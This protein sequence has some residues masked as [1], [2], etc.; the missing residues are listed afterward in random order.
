MR[1]VLA[2][3]ALSVATCVKLSNALLAAAALVDRLPA[4]AGRA[5]RC[6]ISQALSRSR[7]SCRL[8]ADLLP[9][10]V[11]Q[12]PV[13][14]ARPVRPAHIVSS[15]THS[16]IFDAAHARDRRCRSRSSARSACA[17]RGRSRS[18]SRSC[19]STRSS[20][21]STRT[22][23]CIRA[24]S[25]RACPSSSCSG[26]RGRGDRRAGRAASGPLDAR[27]A[28]CA[29]A[30]LR[31]G[32]LPPHAIAAERRGSLWVLLR[33]RERSTRTRPSSGC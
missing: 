19:C 8:L 27:A 25:T 14:A 29:I 32:L 15:W 20:T 7:R 21:A 30:Q 18:C 3:C 16:S 31:A 22:P 5:T 13:V 17:G 9:E 33:R 12:P 4:R 10:A 28:C 24:S 6:R 26:L 2:G 23:H 11:R 1:L